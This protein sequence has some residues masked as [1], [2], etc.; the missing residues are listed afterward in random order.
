MRIVVCGGG[1]IGAC[2]AYSL[3]RRGADVVVV[4]RTAIAAAA[5]GK[6][7]GFLALDWCDGTPLQ[8]LARRSFALHAGLADEVDG[9]WHY[10]RMTTYAGH[11]AASGGPAR[12]GPQL[13]WIAPEVTL[14]RRLG[15]T[16]TTA[17]VE[18][19]AFTRAMMAAAAAQGAETRIG[20]VTGIARRGDRL[21]GIE[22]DGEM[23]ACDAAVIAM[24]PWSALAARWLQFP[25]V[26]GLKGHE[27]V[28]EADTD[29]PADA[30]F[31][32]YQEEG[33]V[34]LSPEIFP[35]ADGTIYVCAIS[36]ETPVPINP[37]DVV[38]DPGAI[39]RLRRMCARISPRMAPS[40]IRS[41]GACHRP[42]TWDG[43]PIIGAVRDVAGAYVATGHSVWGILNAPA[44]GEAVA[45]LILDGSA[46]ID[47]SPF[48]PG[49]FA[50]ND[51]TSRFYPG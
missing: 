43:L 25:P 46:Q 17:Q 33:G 30:L 8:E 29:V 23:L 27:I 15:T 51:H 2:I 12:E 13:G 49:R 20:T 16:T 34:A 42:V 22:V 48:D 40:A 41:T 38:P 35:R 18:P 39:E 28:F 21:Q 1:V 5:S 44:T 10:R 3:G 11:A 19:A 50:G 4:E 7:G 47:L 14:T 31:I 9:E 36:T 37:A 32:E 24:G 26:Y 6:S 45:Q